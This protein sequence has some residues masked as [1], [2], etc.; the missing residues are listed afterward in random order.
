MYE[1]GLD[2]AVLYLPNEYGIPWSG[3]VEIVEKEDSVERSVL[4][5]DGQKIS[6]GRFSEEFSGTIHA[7]DIPEKLARVLPTH[8]QI[9][10][11]HLTYRVKT[12]F[13][14]RI[15]IVYNISARY[16]DKDLV[17][18]EVAPIVLEFTTRK[19]D[20]PYFKPS[21]HFVVDLDRANPLVSARIEELFYGNDFYESELPS[22]DDILAI[23]EEQSSLIIYDHGDGTWS[24][25][26]PDSILAMI[27]DTTFS[28]D[29]P[30]A[31]YLTEDSYSVH[32]L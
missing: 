19:I 16:S 7:F 12:E 14:H 4:Y 23:F 2:Q 6:R 22:I 15:H 27:N 30:S 32:S 8:S 11:F 5:I 10:E 31:V 29:W 20:V 24:A 25:E 18:D 28:I 9:E 13:S 17:T 3:L 26:G 1:H 21:A